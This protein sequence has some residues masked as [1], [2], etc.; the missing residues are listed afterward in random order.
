MK[1]TILNT[2]LLFIVISITTGCQK[3]SHIKIEQKDNQLAFNF[4]DLSESKNSQYILYDIALSREA[5]AAD[6]CVHWEI[7]RQD[8]Y[9][10]SLEHPIQNNILL[11]GS[12]PEAMKTTV[13]PKTLA[14]GEYSIAASVGVLENTEFK[15]TI[16]V[17]QNFKLTVSDNKKLYIENTK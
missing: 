4:S 13:S 6:N 11:Y 7:V 15:K 12:K 5:C 1:N 14:T 3:F 16:K 9:F 8:T 2:L 17:F 10:D